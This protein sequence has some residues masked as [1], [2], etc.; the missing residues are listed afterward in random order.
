MQL[1]SQQGLIWY[2]CLE[3]R[4][5][6]K[7]C[8]SLRKIYVLRKF[9]LGFAIGQKERNKLI[10]DIPDAGFQTRRERLGSLSLT[11]INIDSEMCT[12][13]TTTPKGD[14]PLDGVLHID[15]SWIY[16]SQQ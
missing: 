13:R 2:I 12:S 9:F 8:L 4:S 7:D 10:D 16:Q 1:P 6:T 5:I 14:L 3:V 15:I 11:V